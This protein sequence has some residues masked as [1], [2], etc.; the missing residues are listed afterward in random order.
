[1]PVKTQQPPTA[2]KRELDPKECDFH[3]VE[4]FEIE[5]CHIYEY[6]REL[7]KQTPRILDLFDR[8]QAGRRAGERTPQFSKARKAYKEVRKIMTACFPDFPL[9][10]G[11]WFP[12]TTWQ[13]LDA[14]V[15]SRL[16]KEVNA[17]PQHYWHSLPS[18]K[19]SIKTFTFE[20]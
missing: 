12:D 6:A 13:E 8:W 11:E 19:L 17:G 15:R 10:N 7:T 2:E 4:Q 18:H 20:N 3:L 1:S 5:A 16:V 14:E 9:I